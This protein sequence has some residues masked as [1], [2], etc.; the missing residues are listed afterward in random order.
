MEFQV[1]S[2][3]YDLLNTGIELDLI[4]A[5]GNDYEQQNRLSNVQKKLKEGEKH[6]KKG[7]DTQQMTIKGKIGG[8][9]KEMPQPGD[10]A[11]LVKQEQVVKEKEDK[12]NNAIE[13]MKSKAVAGGKG[14]KFGKKMKDK[15]K[16]EDREK[17]KSLMEK[18]KKGPRGMKFKPS[19]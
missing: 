13:F 6:I 18:A 19:K 11:S 14:V 5:D 3:L 10:W 9:Q 12:V 2:E 4:L 17:A 16:P 1:H 7:I 8:E 15:R